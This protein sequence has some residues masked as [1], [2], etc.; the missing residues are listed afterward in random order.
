M[1]KLLILSVVVLSF[2]TGCLTTRNGSQADNELPSQEFKKKTIAIL[3]VKSQQKLS[4]DSVTPMKKALNARI[5]KMVRSK[6]PDTIIIEQQDSLEKISDA[7]KLELI[8][9]LITGYDSTGAY[10]KKLITALCS[11]LRSD[12][13]L[14]PT[15]KIEQF[16]MVLAKTFNSSLEVSML[17][18]TSSEPIW[19]GIGDFKRHGIYGLGGVE[20]SEAAQELVN[21]SFGKL[22]Q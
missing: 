19:S 11:T 8:D 14:L 2:L 3:P 21:L 4:T 1:K 13:I 16:D 5:G 22:E 15:L 10:D 12:Y 7:G 6:L 17:S 18:K 9:K 20:N